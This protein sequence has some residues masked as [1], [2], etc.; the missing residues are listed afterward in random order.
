MN[1]LDRLEAEHQLFLRQLDG[2]EC[3]LNDASGVDNLLCLQKSTALIHSS[4]EHHAECEETQ[5]FPNLVPHL[6]TSGGPLQVMDEEHR[7]LRHEADIILKTPPSGEAV[8]SVS[9][10]IRSYIGVLRDHIAKENGVLFPMSRSFLSS[11][12]LNE[13]DASCPHLKGALPT[14]GGHFDPCS[15]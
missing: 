11:E 14:C 12:R 4:L 10:A 13:L 15:H 3:Y 8:N 5:L 2:L 9:K 1:L 6:G 7:M